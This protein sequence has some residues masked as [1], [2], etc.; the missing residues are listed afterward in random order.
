[1][2]QNM[3]NKISLFLTILII[4]LFIIPQITLA[5]WWNPGTWNIWE[6][7]NRKSEVNIEQATTATST[8][9]KQIESTAKRADGTEEQEKNRSC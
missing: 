5:S 2:N 3:K 4:S 6:I 7:F 8:L 9:F 1:M